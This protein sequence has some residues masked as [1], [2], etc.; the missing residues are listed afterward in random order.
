[1]FTSPNPKKTVRKKSS[2][3]SKDSSNQKSSRDSNSLNLDSTEDLE[4]NLSIQVPVEP[5]P[6]KLDSLNMNSPN[7][8]QSQGNSSGSVSPSVPPSNPVQQVKKKLTFSTIQVRKSEEV[9]LKPEI[10]KDQREHARVY[11]QKEYLSITEKATHGTS[12]KLSMVD[13]TKFTTA[14]ND[15]L[16]IFQ[17]NEDVENF[18]T[19]F[20]GHCIR[21]DMADLLREFPILERS[22][23]PN[24][25]S[26]RFRNGE[27]WDLL[28]NWDQIGPY[29]KITIPNIAE[30]IDWVVR[31]ASVGC[32]SYLTD[33]SWTH[34]YLMNSAND[35]L[36][37][38]VAATL[39]N[40]FPQDSM[41]GGPLT[42]AVM[43]DKVIYLSSKAITAMRDSITSFDVKT[44]PGENIEILATR[45]L[46]A[47]KCLHSNQSL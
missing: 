26:D 39:K 47:L 35:E 33:L 42:F 7:Q 6:F 20:E 40:D 37:K 4:D 2:N 16:D 21:F 22:T 41:H 12:K 29:K 15:E 9:T 11:S 46:Y 25:D 43:I 34:R 17:E 1:M 13:Y 44:L 45:F 10:T 32:E 38:Q 36:H 5:I 30:T 27:T 18:I 31:Y 24:D 8:D 23:D 28:N 19:N 3:S 14:N